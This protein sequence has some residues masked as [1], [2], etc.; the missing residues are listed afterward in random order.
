MIIYRKNSKYTEWNL[1]Q[2]YFS[3]KISSWFIFGLNS[4]FYGD[5]FECVETVTD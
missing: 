3:I 1:T 5:K 2:S 4:T